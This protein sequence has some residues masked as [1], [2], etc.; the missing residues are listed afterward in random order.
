MS[1]F[2]TKTAN[3]PRKEYKCCLCHDCKFGDS[4][5]DRAHTEC[6]DEEC[7]D[8]CRDMFSE[9]KK[10]LIDALKEK[11]YEGLCNHDCG[12]T[13]DDLAPCASDPTMCEPGFIWKCDNCTDKCEHH[14]EVG[15]CIKAT[16]EEE[17]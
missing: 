15:F 16:K 13:L 8:E 9:T 5:C 12:C 3:K 2:R 4:W 17:R 7:Y 10:M 14:R 6:Y 1:F 11:G